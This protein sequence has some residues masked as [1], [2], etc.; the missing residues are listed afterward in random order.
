MT[1]PTLV[2][3]H[4]VLD[5]ERRLRV[6]V[7][8]ADRFRP[9]SGVVTL[10]AYA[11]FEC[12]DCQA[13]HGVFGALSEELRERVRFVHRHFPLVSSRP[14]AM[15]SALAVEAAGAQGAFWPMYDRLLEMDPRRGPGELDRVAAELGL[16]VERLHRDVRERTHAERIWRDMRGGRASGVTGTPGLFLEGASYRPVLREDA[17]EA[18]LRA[19]LDA[20]GG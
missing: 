12:P 1:P 10:V 2:L 3:P 20:V 7:E 11:D 9:T 14:R 17:L 15:Q 4:G 16:D 13:F 8:A 18:D 6:P 19:A 5:P